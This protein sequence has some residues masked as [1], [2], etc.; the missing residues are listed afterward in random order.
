MGMLRAFNSV[1]LDMARARPL[2]LAEGVAQALVTTVAGIDWLADWR[3]ADRAAST[4]L[5]EWEVALDETFEGSV[6]RDL[7]AALPD[8]AVVLV[9]DVR[10]VAPGVYFVRQ[11]GAGG[12]QC[13]K[14][15]LLD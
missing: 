10:H 11:A 2:E 7:E 1:A 3:S 4:A 6:A 14:V 12:E 13:R 15:L 9:G 5:A 8:D